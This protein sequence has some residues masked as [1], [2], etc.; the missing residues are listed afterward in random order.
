MTGIEVKQLIR[1]SGV[2]CWQAAEKGR[3]IAAQRPQADC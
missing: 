1:F 3:Y 2:K